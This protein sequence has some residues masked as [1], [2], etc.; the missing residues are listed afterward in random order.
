MTTKAKMTT[1]DPLYVQS[2]TRGPSEWSIGSKAS[3][4]KDA[5][6]VLAHPVDI[7]E[8]DCHKHSVAW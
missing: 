8:K 1:K 6:Y 5:Q 3:L 4:K 2:L 7:A